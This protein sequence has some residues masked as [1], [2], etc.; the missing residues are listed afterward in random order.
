MSI[1]FSKVWAR[2]SQPIFERIERDA[3]MLPAVKACMT[4]YQPVSL[5]ED[6]QDLAD[7][8]VGLCSECG[9]RRSRTHVRVIDNRNQTTIS[10]G[11][12]CILCVNRM[13]HRID[14]I[15]KNHRYE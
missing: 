11:F 2:A 4:I 12:L 9:V 7:F 5:C 15:N 10:R 1:D 6:L 14:R 8:G 13:K 3:K